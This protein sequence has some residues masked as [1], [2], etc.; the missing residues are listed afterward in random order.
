MIA[1]LCFSHFVWPPPVNSKF[2]CLPQQRTTTCSKGSS[3]ICF[4][5]LSIGTTTVTFMKCFPTHPC[6]FRPLLRPF[7]LA[8][9]LLPFPKAEFPTM[10]LTCHRVTPLF[11]LPSSL[12][13]VCGF[14]PF[15]VFFRHLS[16]ETSTQAP[17][18][19]FTGDLPG[20]HEPHPLNTDRTT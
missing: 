13:G 8:T 3:S 17:S 15:R 14:S 12:I 18:A 19:C 11:P 9:S 2:P 6:H 5:S 16:H 1:K 4:F 7:L 20:I 10:T